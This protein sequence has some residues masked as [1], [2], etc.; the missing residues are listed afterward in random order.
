M[1]NNSAW[2]TVLGLADQA[3]ISG[4]SFIATVIVGRAAGAAELGVYSLG[5]SIAILAG[6]LQ[7]SLVSTPYT[8]YSSRLAPEERRAYAGGVLGGQIGLTA[9]AITVVV[10]GAILAGAGFD[11]GPSPV[12]LTALAAALPFVLFRD[13]AR[14]FSFAHYWMGTALVMDIGVS[15][16]QLGLLMAAAAWGLLSGWAAFVAAGSAC[17]VAGA[18]W[19]MAAGRRE[20]R[21][22]HAAVRGA[23]VRNWTLGRWIVAS[24]IV[25]TVNSDVVL[26]W[27][28]AFMLGDGATGLFA[29]AVTV[30]AFSN[31]VMLGATHGLT[32][33]IARAFAEGGPPDVRRVVGQAT[34][35]LI[36]ATTLFAL[37]V[38]AVAGRLLGALYGPAFSGQA[39]TAIILAASTVVSSS[40]VGANIGL[41]ALERSDLNLKANLGGLVVLA[42]TAPWLIASWGVA[43]AATGVL[44]GATAQ[45][46][47]RAAAFWQLTAPRST[48]EV[49]HAG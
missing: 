4:T 10:I 41:V 2:R 40:T 14:R 3:V 8:I 39:T 9:L 35:W 37:V 28:I 30:V 5:L 33:R 48:A 23:L 11:A 46:L 29:A 44:C 26:V 24:Q 42:L 6:V 20:I 12:L 16:L 17:A 25:S 49:V 45:S 13:F 32:P 22:A 38:V 7:E 18:A 27:L 43:G 1:R 36:A 19:W 31:P 21:M 15:L 34:C 47:A